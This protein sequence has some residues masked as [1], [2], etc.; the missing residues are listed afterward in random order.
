MLASVTGHPRVVFMVR[1][2][3]LPLDKLRE[4]GLELE[5]EFEGGDGLEGR[6]RVGG[7]GTA[8]GGSVWSW[9]P[10]GMTGA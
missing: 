1:S 10:L 5:V 6:I 7:G 2:S 4:N 3:D 8:G 9:L